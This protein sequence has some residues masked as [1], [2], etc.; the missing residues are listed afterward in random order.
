MGPPLAPASTS[1][2]IAAGLGEDVGELGHTNGAVNDQAE[3]EEVEVTTG[4][5]INNMK[6]NP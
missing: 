2:E 5:V 3:E 4:S 6:N 1:G